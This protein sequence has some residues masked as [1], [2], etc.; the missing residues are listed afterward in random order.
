MQ[1]LIFV[2]TSLHTRFHFE[3]LKTIIYPLVCIDCE[4]D[5][6]CYKLESCLIFQNDTLFCHH[7]IVILNDGSIMNQI[8]VFTL[9]NH[10][11]SIDP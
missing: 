2:C 5:N 3:Y 4:S 8:F 6:I 1:D 7:T 9:I 11:N 10:L